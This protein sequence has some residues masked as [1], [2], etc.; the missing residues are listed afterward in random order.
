MKKI[1]CLCLT[2]T[3]V[4]SLSSLV[5]AESGPASKAEKRA[6]QQQ[7]DEITAKYPGMGAQVIDKADLEKVV[8]K[9]ET[10]EEFENALK[11]LEIV[12]VEDSENIERS[13]GT[14]EQSIAA[15]VTLYQKTL[16]KDCKMYCNG[17]Y[18]GKLRDKIIVKYYFNTT[19]QQK[20]FYSIVSQSSYSTSGYFS[21]VQ[22]YASNSII[23]SQRTVASSIDGHG[24]ILVQIGGIPVNFVFEASPYYEFSYT[25]L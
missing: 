22:D 24:T 23:D 25:M 1:I 9:F 2:L 3:L 8:L 13:D 11:T 14:V 16:T 19:Y 17:V 12:P 7:L 10:V 5:F 20:R 6:M 4:L 18:V 15:T 21:W